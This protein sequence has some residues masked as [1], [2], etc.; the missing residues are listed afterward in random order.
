MYEQPLLVLLIQIVF[1]PRPISEI[2]PRVFGG[3]R[4][5]RI[6]LAS[7]RSAAEEVPSRSLDCL[8]FAFCALLIPSPSTPSSKPTPSDGLVYS[9]R[10]RYSRSS[11]ERTDF[12]F[13]NWAM[14][15][16]PFSEGSA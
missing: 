10:S 2:E 4:L 12:S 15:S 14:T 16:L 6:E 11:G 5:D 1:E 13:S 7:I 8:A 3:V 9:Q